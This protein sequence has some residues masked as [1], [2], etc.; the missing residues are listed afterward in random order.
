MAIA[1]ACAM[2]AL[3][4]AL[5]LAAITRAP[6][7]T[8]FDWNGKTTTNELDTLDGR[9]KIVSGH[10]LAT[11]RAFRIAAQDGD[12]AAAMRRVYGT[13]LTSDRSDVLQTVL[14]GSWLN[15]VRTELDMGSGGPLDWASRYL[16][17]RYRKY[18]DGRERSD[19]WGEDT[20]WTS[21]NYQHSM[22]VVSTDPARPL[23]QDDSFDLIEEYTYWATTAAILNLIVA[24][25]GRADASLSADQIDLSWVSGLRYVG[26]VF[27][28]VEDSSVACT[29]AAKRH[30][31]CVVG[32]GHGI[33]AKTSSGHLQVVALS[34]SDWWVREDEAGHK[35]HGELD[36][37]YRGELVD[38]VFGDNDPA[39]T[40]A[41]YLAAVGKAVDAAV[42]QLA[43]VPMFE[44]DGSPSDAF[45]ARAFSLAV[46]AARAIHPLITA[47]YAPVAERQRL[48]AVPGGGKED[49]GGA[50]VDEPAGCTIGGAGDLTAFAIAGVLGMVLS[51]RR[52]RA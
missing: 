50:G 48:P 7:A 2:R 24:T 46:D 22:V 42:D 52:Q 43:D 51:R 47:R 34:S 23:G 3:T 13:D 31:A 35:P 4:I 15:E 5:T 29:D 11:A 32:D 14:F 19:R 41:R 18:L 16:G 45:D 12:A 36:G 28:I 49:G 20:G 44:P 26:S 37:L 27:H 9:I 6:D 1:M 38:E 17:W 25:K 33:V 8:A 40:N 30:V 39:L 21:S 10:P